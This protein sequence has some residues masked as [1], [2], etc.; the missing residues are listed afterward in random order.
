MCQS[1]HEQ[2]PL[3]RVNAHS[4]DG[5]LKG[6]CSSLAQ[7]GVTSSEACLVRG[8]E[9][10]AYAVRRALALLLTL[11]CVEIIVP[12]T[13][14]AK[15]SSLPALSAN[16]VGSVHFGSPKAPAVASLR[17]FLGTPN[18]KGINTGCGPSFTEIAW[19]DLIV[20]FKHDR[21]TGYRFIRG[22]WPLTTVG[23]PHDRV[24][25]GSPTPRLKTAVGITLG[26]TLGELRRAYGTLRLSG[27]VQWTA[28]NGLIF[29]E[30]STVRDPKSL[31][32]RIAEIQVG[33]CGAF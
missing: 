22:G 32:D 14:L 33:T 19:R 5:L 25:S 15:K 11:V 29:S 13:A 3:T 4:G 16:G 1:C 10:H 2:S 31:T 30:S 21:F 17:R 18:A 26:S 6:H 28:P 8:G 9:R 27:A 23:S 20:E 7:P 12:M 24:T